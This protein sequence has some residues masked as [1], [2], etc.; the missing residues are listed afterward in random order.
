MIMV[1]GSNQK[2]LFFIFFFVFCSVISVAQTGLR[3]AQ[4]K[5]PGDQDMLN[6]R[7]WHNKYQKV[8]GHQ[9]F[10]TNSFLTG[11]VT[12]NG[13]KHANLDLLYD[14]ADDE[15]I[16][17][18]ESVPVIILNKE[19]VD[20]FTLRNGERIYKIVN[21][22]TDTNVIHAGYINVLYEGPSALYVKY[23]KRIQ[24]LA[25]DGRFDLFYQE[26]RIYVRHH[27]EMVRVES[28]KDLFSLM[29]DKKKEIRDFLSS[30]RA[31]GYR[32]SAKEPDTFLPLLKYYDSLKNK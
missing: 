25:V 8:S 26:T 12:M 23:I 11:S 9:F 30:N 19:M 24:P 7:I 20:S 18:H 32:L 2:S 1:S 10:L 22:R 31:N 3:P 28:K 5:R 21:E 13:R 27:S 6:G 15:L 29:K 17:R 16:L 14:I 4:E